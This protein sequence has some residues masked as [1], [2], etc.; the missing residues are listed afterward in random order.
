[1]EADEAVFGV[2]VF[3]QDLGC[4]CS[5]AMGPLLAAQMQHLVSAGSVS[6]PL[7]LSEETPDFPLLSWSSGC[8][9]L[10]MCCRKKGQAGSELPISRLTTLTHSSGSKSLKGGEQTWQCWNLSL[11]APHLAQAY[12]WCIKYII[13]WPS[14]VF[15][16]LYMKIIIIDV[17][18]SKNKLKRN[19]EWLKLS[20]VSLNIHMT[21]NS[22]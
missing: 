15:T 17:C 10:E 7:V 19:P 9:L 8:F 2:P 13:N 21:Y 20:S 5:L 12:R 18:N 16:S 11:L 22:S 6:Q 1:M 4:S 3:Q 14:Q